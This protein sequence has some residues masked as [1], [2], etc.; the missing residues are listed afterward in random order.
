MAAVV[1]EEDCPRR[2]GHA[3][4]VDE[5]LVVR[6]GRRVDRHLG[7]VPR[8]YDV[9]SLAAAAPE[10]CAVDP[11]PDHE[12]P[13][14]SR[15][16]LRGHVCEG[17]RGLICRGQVRRSCRWRGVPRGRRVRGNG[18][19]VRGVVRGYG[20]P[21]IPYRRAVRGYGTRVRD[22]VRGYGRPV[23]CRRAV[24]RN[25]RAGRRRVGRNGRA[26]RRRVGRKG[27]ARRRAVRRKGRALRRRVSRKGRAWRRAV[28]RN[29]IFACRH[30]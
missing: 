7:P 20:R 9:P 28:R 23:A 25:G 21:S 15:P 11:T 29:G 16:P 27:R 19:R 4:R 22:V 5:E 26:G 2:V 3:A 24:G 17:A 10:G 1:S 12:V 30:V 14:V 6:P 13:W 8:Y 18:T